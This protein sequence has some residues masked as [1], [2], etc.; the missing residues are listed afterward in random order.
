[1]AAQRRRAARGLALRTRISHPRH[2]AGTDRLGG[3]RPTERHARQ[4]NQAGHAAAEHLHSGPVSAG[5]QRHRALGRLVD[6]PGLFDHQP[7]RAAGRR[8]GSRRARHGDPYRHAVIFLLSDP[9]PHNLR[10]GISI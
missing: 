9:K 4:A 2:R 10:L 6:R 7:A 3:H 1:M 8:R 5:D